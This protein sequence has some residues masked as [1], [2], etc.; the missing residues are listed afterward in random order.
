MVSVDDAEKNTRFALEHGG[1]TFP[2]LSDPSK[3]MAKTYGVLHPRGFCNRWT[4]YIDKEG[5]I[6][7][8]DKKVKPA[9]AGA[10]VA[11]ALAE[12]G[13]AASE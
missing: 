8:I 6:Q 5:V 10:D 11:A 12:L 3:E 4:F 7:K 13:W 1:N 2:I 9:T